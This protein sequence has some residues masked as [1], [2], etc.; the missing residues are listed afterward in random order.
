MKEEIVF[1]PLTY[2]ENELEQIVG[3]IRSNLDPEFTVDFFKWKHLKNPFGKSYGLVAW[4]GD[5][6]VGLRVFMFWEFIGKDNKILRSIRP[7]DTVVDTNFRGRGLFKKLTLQGLE[8]CSGQ[9]DFVFNTPNNN[10]LPG[11]L[12]MGWEK[13]TGTSH[14]KIGVINP[15][16]KTPN[17]VKSEL[18][19]PNVSD[20]LNSTLE[21]NKTLNY[22]KWRYLDSKYRIQNYE[23]GTIVFSLS[24]IKGIR[25]FIVYE[26]LGEKSDF[27]D[28]MLAVA[29]EFDAY[30]VYYYD[31]KDFDQLKLLTSFDR[32]EAVVVFK[33]TED[34]LVKE[35][36][37]SLG[38]LE[39]KL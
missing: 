6:I 28:I 10:S 4:A 19:A 25:S 18:G 16:Q 13:S 32:K 38:D 24:K 37:F 12:K 14:F 26:I 34:I 22:L 15:L 29:K 23:S 36:N 21:T 5:K 35:F 3:L 30:L 7:V 31:S 9:Y 17:L 8:N 1:K 33:E 20:R 39:G 27:N 11:Y 2:S